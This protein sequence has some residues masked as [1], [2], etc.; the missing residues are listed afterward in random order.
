[1]EP[2]VSSETSE[3]RTQTPGNYP[4]RNNFYVEFYSKIK[5]E[6]LVHLFGFIIWINGN[7]LTW[8]KCLCVPV[9]CV[10]WHCIATAN[11]LVNYRYS[12]HLPWRQTP[13]W[14][15]SQNAFVRDATP[16]RKPPT[17]ALLDSHIC[18]QTIISAAYS[19]LPGLPTALLCGLYCALSWSV[20]LV[21]GTTP[22]RPR[23][24]PTAVW[25]RW[26]T[27]WQRGS[28]SSN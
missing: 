8:S 11:P 19:N 12:T 14:D 15:K 10:S 21:A 25:D 16:V 27:Q 13:T 9:A 26:W 17:A 20:S 1:M 24:V 4:K 3:I 7:L 2:T 22:Q 6:K 5:F 23:F 18:H 28:F